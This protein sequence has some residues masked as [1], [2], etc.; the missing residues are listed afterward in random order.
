M[1]IYIYIYIYKEKERERERETYIYIYIYILYTAVDGTVYTPFVIYIRIYI[2]I[3]TYIVT[4]ISRNVYIYI[5]IYISSLSYTPF[6][7]HPKT[8]NYN[9]A[10]MKARKH[11]ITISREFRHCIYTIRGKSQT[12][13]QYRYHEGVKTP[14]NDF[15]RVSSLYIHH[16]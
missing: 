16:S 14:N 9:I 10:T 13:K 11:Q 5:Y 12:G 15:A 1:S 3:Y 6:A 2:Y 7:R 4:V 8:S